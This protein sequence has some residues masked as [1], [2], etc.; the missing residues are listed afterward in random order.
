MGM[1]LKKLAAAFDKFEDD[2]IKFERIEKPRHP[3][4]DI[5]A[6]LMLH[7]LVPGIVDMVSAAEHDQI[8]LAVSGEEL[9]KVATLDV[10]RDLARCGVMYDEDDEALSMFV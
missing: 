7:D 3:R 4:P 9:A 5:C 2:Y 8:H 1:T 10:V 6:F